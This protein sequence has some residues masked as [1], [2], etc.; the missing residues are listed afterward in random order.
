MSENIETIVPATAEYAVC[1]FYPDEPDAVVINPVVAWRIV[2]QQAQ[3]V[4]A[5]PRVEPDG[6]YALLTPKGAVFE[7]G[8]RY[9]TQ[10]EWQA[11]M[12]AKRRRAA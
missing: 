7:E 8:I 1:E 10:K 3:P 5:F 9:A 11:A 6:P 4:C 2:E 12:A